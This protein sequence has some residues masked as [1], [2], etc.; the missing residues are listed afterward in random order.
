VLQA[1]CSW[2]SQQSQYFLHLEQDSCIIYVHISLVLRY[3]ES[4]ST[5]RVRTIATCLLSQDLY[6]V[7]HHTNEAESFNGN[8]TTLEEQYSVLRTVHQCSHHRR[9]LCSHVTSIACMLSRSA[10][11]HHEDVDLPCISSY[12]RC[13]E[14]T[15]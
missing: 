10:W 13:T 5:N 8:Y 9:H 11:D 3:L 14:A 7:K 12:S 1:Q 2:L 15:C 4:R 6:G